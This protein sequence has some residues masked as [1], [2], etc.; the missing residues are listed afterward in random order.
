MSVEITGVRIL[1]LLFEAWTV[2]FSVDGHSLVGRVSEYVTKDS[3]GIVR[4]NSF[5]AI[6][7]EWLNDYQSI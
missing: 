7:A 2:S 3:D 5:R 6:I 1:L 4:M